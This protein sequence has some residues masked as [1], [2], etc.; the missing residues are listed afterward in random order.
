VWFPVGLAL[1]LAFLTE[2]VLTHGPLLAV[3]RW[4]RDTVHGWS[5][6]NSWAWLE[7]MA[8]RWT[9]IGL[10]VCSGSALTLVA[11][12]T[13][14]RLRS[15]RPILVALLAAVALFG[16]VIPG[17]IIIGR[18]GPLGAPVPPGGWGWFPS[19]HTATA[20]ICLGTAALLLASVLPRLRRLLYGATAF[21]C[22]G[23]GFFLIWR[24]YHW[25]LDVLA[26]GCLTGIVL[27]CLA[28]I[29][30]QP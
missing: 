2:Q 16:T 4:T 24:D 27:W 17:K 13:A 12:L 9:D 8:E 29:R 20:S 26:S 5:A 7:L 21:V 19:G 11:L 1:V 25:L 30:L 18:P 6:R 28:R 15:W 23:V 10:A 22:V 3:D 14:A